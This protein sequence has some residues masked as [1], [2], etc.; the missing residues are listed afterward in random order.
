MIILKLIKFI[1][2]DSAFY[3]LF[4]AIFTFL[5][6]LIKNVGIVPVAYG[7]FN[8][9]TFLNKGLKLKDFPQEVLNKLNPLVVKTILE[10]ITPDWDSCIKKAPL[11]KNLFKLFMSFFSLGLIRPLMWNSAKYTFGLIFT[12]IG[13]ALNEA[14]STI[15]LLKTIS[16][17]VL[18]FIPIMPA[19]NNFI[20]LFKGVN[21]P[22]NLP[23]KN[24]DIKESINETSSLLTII[25][26]FIFGAGAILA[27]LFTGDY[28][29]SSTIRAIPGV[30]TILDTFYSAGNYILSWFSSPPKPDIDPS[31]P[32]D[33]QINY[34]EKLAQMERTDSGSSTDTITGYNQPTPPSTRPGSPIVWPKSGPGPPG[35]RLFESGSSGSG[36]GE[37][38]FGSGP[39]TKFFD[40]NNNK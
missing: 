12:S 21:S 37:P 30:P 22:I 16:D 17:Y 19:I 27:I 38:G 7:I 1:K 35:P 25:G 8:V 9:Y 31:S 29:I 39:D 6:T 15:S 33:I 32:V 3:T 34:K 14:L 20:N 36:T 28:F 24:S 26:L 5:P 18:N 40:T 10:A 4:R 23:V 11:F 2:A 13:I